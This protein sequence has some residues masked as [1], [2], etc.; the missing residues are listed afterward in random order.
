MWVDCRIFITSVLEALQT[1]WLQSGDN[2]DQWMEMRQK[3]II[4][5]MN[6]LY[7]ALDLSVPAFFRVYLYI[8]FFWNI[9]S[10]IS[11]CYYRFKWINSIRVGLIWLYRCGMETSFGV[12]F[13]YTLYVDYEQVFDWMLCFKITTKWY[14]ERQYIW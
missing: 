3:S 12:K 11:L 4:V 14:P 13:C 7:R 8:T 1:V 5:Q 10:K 9:F 2:C 6:S